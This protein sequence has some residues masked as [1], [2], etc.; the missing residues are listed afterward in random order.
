[1][2]VSA[3]SALTRPGNIVFPTNL[4]F[5]KDP[6]AAGG[7]MARQRS[8]HLILYGPRNRR[9]LATDPDGNPLH[10]CEW[11]GIG[12]GKARL[13]R[14]RL[15]LEWGQ[16]IGL[17]PEGL[18]NTTTLDLSR[19]PGWERLRP[20]DLRQMAAQAMRVPLEEVKF[21]YGDEDLVID[22]RGIATIRHKK[23]AFYVLDVGLFEGE[24]FMAC[25]GAM[26]WAAI[27]FLPVVE[28]F[29][30]L[31]PGTGSAAF[32]LIRGLYDDQTEGTPT[33]LRYRGIPTYPSE[34]A[35]RLFSSFF[36]PQAPG[37]GDPFPIF[38]DV[39]RSHEVTWLP[40]P[41]PPLRYFDPGRN[42]CV[43]VKG[44]AL[45][46][47]TKWDDP[48]GLPFV[49]PGPGFK[50]LERI[51]T[52][53]KGMVV[54]QDHDTKVEL[55]VNPAWGPLQDSIPLSH[56]GRGEG[57]GGWRSL[58]GGQ[59]PQVTPQEAFSAVLLYPDDE[60]EIGEISSQPFVADHI[61]D[62]FEQDPRLA[63]SL[64]KAGHVLIDNFDGA[65]KTC[66]DLDRP[67]TYTVLYAR[68]A[69]AQKQGQNL[70]NELARSQ[71]FDRAKQISFMPA[72][73]AQEAY[74]KSYD[75][76]YVW[77]PFAIF[78]DALKLH[79]TA[80]TFTDAIGQGG[81]AFIV[82]PASLQSSL[83][84]Q[85]QLQVISE[86]A[87]ES[88]PTFRMHRTILPKARIRAGLTLFQTVKV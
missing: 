73:G 79:E 43:T 83:Q 28:L 20:D 52:T 2:D 56:E 78:N 51:V 65:I 62:S 75:L 72:A 49:N 57:E 68:L 84:M 31:L 8:G 13:L 55:P 54:L 38:M 47:V 61:H 35:Y 29:Q 42:L 16:W 58:F 14:A 22:R 6:T 44:Q 12:Q 23:D 48:T 39:P 27:D 4:P 45:Q 41:D 70:W 36:S 87:V 26:H 82:G 50:P 30:S 86:E 21:F 67:R 25:M 19:K 59:P 17:K 7:R 63:A 15:R 77:I 64:A 1:M 10:E 74:R 33:P 5:L 69:Y 71:R 32:E 81:L 24:R 34:A 80:R 46:K 88:L 9:I 11:G 85:P 60:T 53:A 40:A 66:L 18:V 3:S 37:G 76:L